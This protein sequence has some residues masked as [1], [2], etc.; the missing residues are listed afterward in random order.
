MIRTF[1]LLAGVSLAVLAC[2]VA[3]QQVEDGPGGPERHPPDASATERVLAVAR[4][5][6]V[7][8][9]L[10]GGWRIARTGGRLRVDRPG[11]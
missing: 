8:C 1:G 3:A 9:E 2:P 4:G 10:P 6:A 5:D 7:A 11:G